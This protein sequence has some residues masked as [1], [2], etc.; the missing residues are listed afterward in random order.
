MVEM[1]ETKTWYEKLYD[2]LQKISKSD[3]DDKLT[4]K[5]DSA[6]ANCQNG[7]RKSVVRAI[8]I[9]DVFIQV[10]K[11]IVKSFQWIVISTLIIRWFLR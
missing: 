10:V 3:D 6:L 5:L 4:A 1:V 8:L 2:F 7:D 11:G 9:H